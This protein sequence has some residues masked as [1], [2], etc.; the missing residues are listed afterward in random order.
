MSNIDLDFVFQKAMTICEYC[1]IVLMSCG[2]INKMIAPLSIS[3][4]RN[5]PKVMGKVYYRSSSEFYLKGV[6]A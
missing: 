5:N 4:E 6:F 2:N 1:T 3:D